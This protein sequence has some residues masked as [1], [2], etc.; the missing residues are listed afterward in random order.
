MKALMIS[1]D[2]S[3]SGKTSITA[4]IASALSMKYR[5]QTYKVGMD[6]IDPSYLTAASGRAC[7]NVDGFVMSRE[8]I[9][10]IVDHAAE[11]ADILLFEGVRGLYE[12]AS[13]L[14]ET[15][16][17][18]EIAKLL[19]I[20][21]ILVVN[22][23]SITR[24]AAAL[25]K[26]FV[27]FDPEVCIRGVILNNIGGRTHREK[28]ERAVEESCGIPVLGAIPQ[29]AGMALEMRHLGLV[30]FREGMQDE[31]YGESLGRIERI[32]SEHVDLDRLL[33]CAG[34]YTRSEVALPCFVA[35]AE[36]DVKIAIAYDEAFNFYYADLFDVLAAWGTE[37][38]FWSPVRDRLPEADGYIIGGGYPEAFAAE[39]ER[40]A[41][42]REALREASEAGLPVYAECG[43]LI[44]L[45]SG[46]SIT[47]DFHGIE[48]GRTYEMCGALDA[49]VVLPA[50]RIVSYVEGRSC[51]G[52][53]VGGHTFRG[54]EFHYSDV[55]FRRGTRFCYRLSRGTGIG[56][57]LDGAFVRNTIASYTHLAPVPSSAMFAEFVL[58]CREGRGIG[59]IP[60]KKV[61]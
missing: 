53:P 5:V 17:S 40:N 21:V 8:E 35:A 13:A 36:K 56:D 4:G 28:A 7:R 50:R 32:V 59:E 52:S 18:A 34:E 43:G 2:R 6:Y 25:V 51:P 14:D 37:C 11:G 23:R 24:S 58:R 9:R 27:S 55:K 20:P 29:S 45:A 10:G 47:R 42:A 54:H 15:G 48:G 33:A 1:A 22:A 16:S 30:P 26:G 49:E 46:L 38:T 57:G 44:Y 41:A 31:G 39:L 3:G 60:Y 12:G 61:R 19:G